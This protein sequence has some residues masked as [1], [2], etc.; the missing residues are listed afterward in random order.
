MHRFGRNT[1]VW[2]AIVFAALAMGLG[3]T[4]CGGGQDDASGSGAGKSGSQELPPPDQVYTVRGRIVDLPDPTRP[5]SG[6]QVLHEAIDNFVG[7][8]GRIVGMDAMTMPFTPARELSLEGFA[9]DD[10]VELVFEVR[11]KAPPLSRVVEMRKL[12][13]DTQLELRKAQPPGG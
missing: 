10:Y 4:G 12:P 1:L 2:C 3:G 13:A 8:D 11:W 6:L 7:R 5:A 9:V